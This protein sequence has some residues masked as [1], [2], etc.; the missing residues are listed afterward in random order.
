MFEP[1]LLLARADVERVLAPEACRAAVEDA[2][3]QLAQAR[4]AP[5]GI[6]GMPASGGSFHVKAGFLSLDRPYFAAKLNANFPRNPARHGLPTIQGLV[7]LFDAARGVVLA[8]M[9]SSSITALRTAA[10]TAAAA[11][12]LARRACDTIAI[13]GCGAQAAAQL[14]A[15]AHVR[16][17]RRVLVHDLDAARS[18]AFARRLEAELGVP[19]TPVGDVAAAVSPSAIVVTCTT[20]RRFFVTRDMVAP[21][22]FIAAVGADHEEKQEIEPAVLA[23]AKVVTDLTV[24]A[25]AIGD[26]HHAIEAGAMAARDVPGELGEVIA[27]SRPGRENDEEIIVFDSTGTGLQDVAAAIAAYRGALREGAARRFAFGEDAAPAEL[28]SP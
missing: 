5:P 28:T 3:L 18:A 14:R 2:F 27:G 10:A 4:T 7:A 13:C 20:A 17:P 1:A 23:A 24:Q 22:T 6:L 11:R 9:D 8:V 26:L 19:I 21:G 16:M 12:F 25:A 15:V